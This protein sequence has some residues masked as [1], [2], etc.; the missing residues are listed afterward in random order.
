[1][2][3]EEQV[4]DIAQGNG[5]GVEFII[6]EGG[7][8]QRTRVLPVTSAG[9]EPFQW[10]TPAIRLQLRTADPDVLVSA[11]IR[12]RGA[13]FVVNAAGDEGGERICHTLAEA[14]LAAESLLIGELEKLA[15]QRVRQ[16]WEAEEFPRLYQEAAVGMG[17][18]VGTLGLRRPD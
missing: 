6:Q 17:A 15:A 10:A 9:W 13:G 14:V 18:Y 5:S 8:R 1:M 7:G 2:E 3:S 16:D 12:A 11:V 4:N